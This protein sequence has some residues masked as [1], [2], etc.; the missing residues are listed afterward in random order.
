MRTEKQSLVVIAQLVRYALE[1]Q[2]HWSAGY[3]GTGY[4]SIYRVL[5]Y[6]N[7][8]CIAVYSITRKNI[9]RFAATAVVVVVVRRGEVFRII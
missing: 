3:L 2:A 6:A 5:I 8:K 1:T 9:R 7:E 4:L